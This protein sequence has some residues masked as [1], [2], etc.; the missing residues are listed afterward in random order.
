[1]KCFNIVIFMY[2]RGTYLKSAVLL[3]FV[4]ILDIKFG[5]E[6]SCVKYVFKFYEIFKQFL[7]KFYIYFYLF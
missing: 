1:M 6:L 7:C 3:S 2:V 4:K 5:N